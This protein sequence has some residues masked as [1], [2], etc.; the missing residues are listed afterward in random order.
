MKKRYIALFLICF[1]LCLTAIPGFISN[2]QGKNVKSFTSALLNKKYVQKINSIYVGDSVDVLHFYKDENWL[3]N[4]GD[5]TFYA[6]PTIINQMIDS[7]SAN[8]NLISVSNNIKNQKEYGISEEKS[9]NI[10]FYNEDL[11]GNKN[12]FSKIF[13][14]NENSDR[15]MIYLKS[16]KNQTVYSTINDLYPYLTTKLEIFS[17]NQLFPLVQTKTESTITNIECIEYLENE[18]KSKI[19][20]SGDHDFQEI[21]HKL[22]SS[23]GGTFFQEDILQSD[24]IKHS[25]TIILTD[26]ENKYYILDIYSYSNNI[27]EQYFVKTSFPEKSK[28]VNYVL[29]I[30]AWTKSRLI[31]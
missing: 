14:G 24:N 8:R 11:V 26:N 22:L 13:F 17:L 4:Y 28:D 3:C 18:K 31:F 27:G 19:K 2:K 9:F 30:S 7:F 21:V 1:T 20:R 25:H 5:L 12:E 29:E 15:T 23:N 10:S 16:N 6:N